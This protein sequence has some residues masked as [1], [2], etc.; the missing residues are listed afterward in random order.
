MP[1]WLRDEPRVQS[2]RHLSQIDVIAPERVF[3]LSEHGDQLS[4]LIGIAT[5][6]FGTKE[7]MDG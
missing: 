6:L 2:E 3:E 7:Q 5:S 1:E 4:G